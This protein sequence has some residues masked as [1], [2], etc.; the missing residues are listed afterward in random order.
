M[1][2]SD[3]NGIKV[4]DPKDVATALNGNRFY[5]FAGGFTIK[6]KHMKQD[7]IKLAEQYPGLTITVGLDDLL[8]AGRTLCSELYDYIAET[9]E[10]SAP[11]AQ[12]AEDLL[13]Q[14]DV[15]EKLGVSRSTLWRWSQIGYLTPVKVGVSI[16]YRSSEVMHQLVLNNPNDPWAQ[17]LRHFPFIQLAMIKKGYMSLDDLTDEEIDSLIQC[18]LDGLDIEE[19]RRK[20]TQND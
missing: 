12:P 17:I 1:L 9:R 10:Q 11:A 8:K 14:A 7:S 16:R 13:T 2:Q 19:L 15:M 20:E 6:S 5:C 3:G 4:V 18:D